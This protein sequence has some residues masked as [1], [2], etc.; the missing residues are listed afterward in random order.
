[1]T[2]GLP[3]LWH[4]HKPSIDWSN[5]NF[6]KH[7]QISIGGLNVA[8]VAK[9]PFEHNFF[10]IAAVIGVLEYCT[11]KYIGKALLELNRVLKPESRAVL[12][13]PNQNHPYAEDM[14]R[15]EK[16]L[17]RPNLFHSQSEFEESLTPLFLIERIDDS[18]VMLKYFVRTIK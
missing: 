14:A 15:L 6:V 16:Y 11:L 5:E 7:E 3:L 9:L 13:I 17:G 12:D 4:R 2:V 18:R 8:E 1:M 10:D